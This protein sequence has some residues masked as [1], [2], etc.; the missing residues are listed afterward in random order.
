MREDS[1]LSRFPI[2]ILGGS[3]PRAAALP[4]A[5][6]DNHPL[7]GYKGV[8]I[9]LEG[10]P[11]VEHVID[12]LRQSD[13]FEPLFIAGPRRIYGERLLGT[14]V[15]DTDL[16]F[17][18][19][20]MASLEH[21]RQAHPGIPVGFT[22]C[23]IL[24][25]PGEL[26]GL[27]SDYRDVSPCDLWYPL[28]R[29]PDDPSRLGAS[30]WKPTYRIVPRAGEPAEEV[31][32]G[33]LVIVDPEAL[34]LKLIYELFQI[35]YRTRNRPIEY[36]RS[37][38]IRGVF[39]ELLRQDALHVLGRRLPNLTW[40]VL[41]T[42]LSGGLALKKGTLT[43]AR[44]EDSLRKIFVRFRHRRKHP[45]RRVIV[46]IVE[47]LSLAL[48]IDTQEEAAAHGGRLASPS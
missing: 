28:V 33:H 19:N 11:I 14:E 41:R 15:I 42:G 4:E 21:V 26:R 36:R 22:T 10:R 27:A 37:A 43:L 7:S 8:D 31:L 23:D 2:V 3:D 32:P 13:C 25:D 45:E 39:L 35:A 38:M 17:S 12:R 20:I 5:G 24:P 18:E 9:L 46:T 40:T 6:R 16:T 48:D 47:A 30:Q 29:V 44:I 1:K 34:R